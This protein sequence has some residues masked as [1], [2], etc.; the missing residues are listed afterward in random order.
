MTIVRRVVRAAAF[1]CLFASSMAR[2]ESADIPSGEADASAAHSGMEEIVVTARKRQ[3]TLADVPISVTA[4]SEQS[5]EPPEYSLVRRLRHPDSQ[6]LFLLR[7]RRTRLRRHPLAG[8]PRRVGRG[9]RGCLHRRHTGAGQHRSSGRRHCAHRDT[10]RASGNAIRPRIARRQ[11]THRHGGSLRERSEHAFSGPSRRH[12]RRRQPRLWGRLR[13]KPQPHR[14]HVDGQA[15][16]VRS[17][18]T[19]GFLTRTYPEAD[20]KSSL[21]QQSGCL[22]FLR[23]LTDPALDTD[24][25]SEHHVANH[26]PDDGGLRLAGPLCPSARIHGEL[27][28]AQSGRQYSGGILRSLGAALDKLQLQGRWIQHRVLDQLLRSR[29][30]QYRG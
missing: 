29:H 11:Y 17:D 1:C 24:R 5:L 16:G 19:A 27:A 25:P 9:Y 22:L 2:P 20:G 12:V 4:F 8:H 7:H 10:E 23:G 13:G 14:Q 26:V 15:G 28:H 30:S 21:C 18:H 6:S 3:E